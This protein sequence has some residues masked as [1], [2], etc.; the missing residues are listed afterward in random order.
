MVNSMLNYG[1]DLLE[2]EVKR[3]DSHG[4]RPKIR[5]IS[6]VDWKKLGFL[7]ELCII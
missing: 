1:Y 7:R 5:S 2:S 6:Y 4:I 3:V